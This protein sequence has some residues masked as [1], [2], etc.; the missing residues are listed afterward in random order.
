MVAPGGK[1]CCAEDP[2]I[3]T[4]IPSLRLPS[5]SANSTVLKAKMRG[6]PALWPCAVGFFRILPVL[7]TMMHSFVCLFKRT[8]SHRKRVSVRDYLFGAG[9]WKC[10]QG[11]V[12]VNRP[13]K[14]RSHCEGLMDDTFT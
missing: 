2:N 14:S 4:S 3:H 7:R 12:L 8:Q 11:T 5:T 10:L 6:I 13:V 9:L 1:H